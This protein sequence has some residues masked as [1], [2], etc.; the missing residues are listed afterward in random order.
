MAEIDFPTSG[1][2]KVPW[3]TVIRPTATSSKAPGPPFVSLKQDPPKKKSPLKLAAK[4]GSGAAVP[5]A[6]A[7]SREPS[8]KGKSEEQSREKASDGQTA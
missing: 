2:S 6:T 1:D 4:L 8:S 3:S 5:V 7:L